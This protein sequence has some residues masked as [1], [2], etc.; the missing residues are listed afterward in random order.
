ML[1]ATVCVRPAPLETQLAAHLASPMRLS[2]EQ[3]VHPAI[4]LVL[5]VPLFRPTARP[6]ILRVTSSKQEEATPAHRHAVRPS[7]KTQLITSVQPVIPHA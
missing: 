6:A 3:H 7:G 2:A 5:H 1:P 4:L